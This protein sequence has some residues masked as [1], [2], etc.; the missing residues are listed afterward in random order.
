MKVRRI[1]LLLAVL[2]VAIVAAYS[3]SFEGAF[4]LDDSGRIVENGAIRDIPSAVRLLTV[5]YIVDLTFAFDY[6]LGGLNPAYY[7]F[8]NLIIH[9]SCSLVLFMLVRVLVLASGRPLRDAEWSAFFVV[10]LWGVHPLTTSAVTYICQRYES[11]M[12]L[13]YLGSMLCCAEGVRRAGIARRV[14]LGLSVAGCLL[15]MLCKQVMITAPF[16]ILVMDSV[17]L[18]GGWRKALKQK[19][20]YYAALGFCMVLLVAFMLSLY[21][22]HAAMFTTFSAKYGRWLYLVNQGRVI[23]NYLKLSVWPYPLSIDYAWLPVR[24]G[25]GLWLSFSAVGLLFLATLWGMVTHPKKWFA[26]FA[27]FVLLSP[28]SSVIP[29][30]DLAFEQRMYLPLAAMIAFIVIMVGSRL[31]EGWYRR[32]A[33]LLS[34]LLAVVLG[35]VTYQR[36]LD[37][38]VPARVWEALARRIPHNLRA[39]GSL[40]NEQ[41]KRQ[42]YIEAEKTAREM[43]LVL[44]EME[45]SGAALYDIPSSSPSMY[46][47]MARGILGQALMGQQRY[48]DALAEF[49]ALVSAYPHDVSSL[50]NRGLALIALGR[51]AEG[52]RDIDAVLS[53]R[54]GSADASMVK[55]QLLVT[56]GRHIEA[57]ELF[58]DVLAMHPE[59]LPA[60]VEAAWLLSVSPVDS[61]RSGAR[62]LSLLNGIEEEM[63][64]PNVRIYDARAAAFAEAGDFDT[65][66]KLQKQALADALKYYSAQDER[67]PQMESR[68]RLYLEG[69]PFRMIIDAEARP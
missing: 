58:E 20:I 64:M 28:S 54:K 41:L 67:I 18:S 9:L 44:S 15:G 37:Y 36:N 42:D 23:L 46:R 32:A 29:L 5:R 69:R 61:V 3:S 30:P 33:G 52:E 50:Q 34:V 22:Q 17:F 66:V 48:I 26:A 59:F 25:I 53:M 51:K 1:F 65:A 57:K 13:F 47:P 63:G 55:A 27:V 2:L 12:S 7:H 38:K 40:A 43:L 56:S 68:L 8:T 14:L 62:A 24:S 4:I 49:D 21:D 6:M 31:R 10:L 39:I 60:R 45:A 35:A 16:M 11:L 19:P